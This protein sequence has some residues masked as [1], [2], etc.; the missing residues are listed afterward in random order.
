MKKNVTDETM[1]EVTKTIPLSLL[2]RPTIFV[3]VKLHITKNKRKANPKQ[4]NTLS[5]ITRIGVDIK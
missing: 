1:N 4:Q 5:I 3:S 2:G